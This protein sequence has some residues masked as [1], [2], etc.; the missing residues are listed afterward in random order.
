[1]ENFRFLAYRIRF[2]FC[3]ADVLD[4][5]DERVHEVMEGGGGV[6]WGGGARMII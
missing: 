1:M 2:D 6:G 5:S 3:G 4:K